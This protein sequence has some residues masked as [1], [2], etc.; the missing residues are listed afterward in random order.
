MAKMK[1]RGEGH[2]D[3]SP[4]VQKTAARR[5]RAPNGAPRPPPEAA[6][7]R[8]PRRGGASRAIEG[9][10]ELATKRATA[11]VELG[12][13]LKGNESRRIRREVLGEQAGRGPA[14]QPQPRRPS[15]RDRLEAMTPDERE[16]V[17][18]SIKGE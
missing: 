3:P 10:T 8:R 6:R 4:V 14:G 7:A 2:A 16:A 5:P 18:A 1:Q 15:L 13:P 17:L 9:G 12:R 11:A